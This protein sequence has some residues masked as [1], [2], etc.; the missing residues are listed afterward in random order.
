M[1]STACPDCRGSGKYIGLNVVEPCLGCGGSG[2][3]RRKLRSGFAM[4][5]VLD[6]HEAYAKHTAEMQRRFA[7]QFSV[8]G[9]K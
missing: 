9:M 4:I 3:Q 1:D 6:D 7:Q 2:Q 5:D 8:T